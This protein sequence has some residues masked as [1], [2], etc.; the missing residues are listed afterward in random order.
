L[1]AALL[2]AAALRRE[3][4]ADRVCFLDLE[5]V[6]IDAAPPRRKRPFF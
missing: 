4:G 3:D 1:T 2:E 5:S 6:D